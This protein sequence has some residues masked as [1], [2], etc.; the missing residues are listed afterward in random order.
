MQVRFR[1]LTTLSFLL[2]FLLTPSFLPVP[3]KFFLCSANSWGAE[4]KKFGENGRDG[5]RG[6]NGQRGQ[7]SDNLTIFADGS[8]MT[9]DLSGENGANG[10]NGAIGGNSNCQDQ[11]NDSERNFQGADGGN[12]GDGGDGGDGGNGGSLTVYTVNP[13]YLK[14]IYLSAAG[15]KGGQSGQ[16]GAAGQGC[17]CKEAYSTQQ[18]CNGNSCTTHEFKC[19]NGLSGSTGRG[20]RRGR[21]GSIGRLTLINRDRT[22]DPD[23]PTATV[24]MS[25]IKDRGLSVSKNIWETRT[26]ATTLFAPGSIVADEYTMLVDR[27]ERSV[28]M[29]WD[30]PRPFQEFADT[31]ITFALSDRGVEITPP[32]EVWFE[33]TTQE[34]ENITEV[35]IS[36]AL[37]AKEATQLQSLGLSGSGTNLSLNLSDVAEKSDL[38]LT[39]FTVK[40]RINRSQ[41]AKYRPVHDY[42]NVYEGKV[43]P[44]LIAYNNN[45]F[46]I[47]L[48]KLPIEPEY[49]KRG[50]AVEVEL[51]A[52][53]SFAGH[54]KQQKIFVREV[55]R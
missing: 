18:V 23:R 25:E 2:A 5:T 32:K 46:A 4:A 7:D 29:V 22:L 16:G 1:Y 45:N 50:L 55:L 26:G 19:Q 15:G 11:P 17:Q 20:G 49:L 31:A 37:T 27:V 52:N 44:D 6:T 28:L 30:A 34:R 41:A 13:E 21:E 39:D 35:F 47:E 42:D 40:Y 9:L 8:P 14:Q 3:A 53:R 54:T 12:G 36:N 24:K 48:G 51:I 10:E 43:T 33:T 38:V